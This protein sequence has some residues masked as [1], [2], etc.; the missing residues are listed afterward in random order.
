M[1]FINI[2][3]HVQ[4]KMHGVGNIYSLL[5][6]TRQAAQLVCLG[7]KINNSAVHVIRIHTLQLLIVN[8]KLQYCINALQ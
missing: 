3:L 7:C 8:K 5:V 1:K 2:L 4:S 6:I